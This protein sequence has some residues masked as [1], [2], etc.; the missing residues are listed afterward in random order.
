MHSTVLSWSVVRMVTVLAAAARL[1]GLGAALVALVRETWKLRA[2]GTLP[3]VQLVRREVR[4][5]PTPGQMALCA[6]AG[7]LLAA[8]PVAWSVALGDASF[9]TVPGWQLASLLPVVATVIVKVLWV[10]FEEL[11]FR[12][13]LITALTRRVAIPVA[14][15]ISA[16]AFAA[17]HGRDALSTVVLAVDGIG[18]AVAYV[19]TGS[20]RAPIAW[21]LGKN[22][23][24]WICTG[25]STLQF[26]PMPWRLAGE[27]SSYAELGF[28]MLLVALTSLALLT[29]R[30]D[31]VRAPAARP[32]LRAF[33]R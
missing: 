4:A 32:S 30:R 18:F 19:A 9:V 33:R 31:R 17:A 3:V 25:A 12:A 7:I 27:V 24:V 5:K 20:I 6:A 13:A 23:A 29:S 28:A 26:A 14:L 8:T 10:F 1:S 21:H 22:L 2:P 11:A 15:A 16:L